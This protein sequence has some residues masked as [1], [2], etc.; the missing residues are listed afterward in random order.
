MQLK[1][2]TPER[3]VLSDDVDQVTLPTQD[4]EITVLPHHIALVSVLKPG[5]LVIKKGSEV[6]PFA[7]SG[8]MIRVTETGV[9]ILADTAERVEEIIEERAR[10]AH[11]AA[12]KLLEEK[13]F[14][15]SEYATIAAKMEK[16][17]ARL[18][19]ARKW[20][21]RGHPPISITSDTQTD[22]EKK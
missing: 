5:E 7:V 8:G 22:T 4:G 21:H 15:A 13:K 16:E 9:T 14:D 18:H 11:E 19:V 20:R 17:L 6:I 10:L 2:V 1:S 3:E 12:Q